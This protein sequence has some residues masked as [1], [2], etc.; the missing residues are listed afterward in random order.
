MA[1]QLR[2]LARIKYADPAELTIIARQYGD[3]LFANPPDRFS[4]QWNAGVALQQLV[5]DGA[6]NMVFRSACFQ[7]SVV[8]RQYFFGARPDGQQIGQNFHQWN[9]VHIGV[10]L[11]RSLL[12]RTIGELLNAMKDA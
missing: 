10:M 5:I 3:A 7:Q 8:C 4:Q 1:A 12:F 2:T 9:H 6:K 11:D